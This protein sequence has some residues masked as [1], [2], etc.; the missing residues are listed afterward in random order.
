MDRGAENGKLETTPFEGPT[1]RPIS[2]RHEPQARRDQ[3]EGRAPHPTARQ[4]LLAALTGQHKKYTSARCY[5]PHNALVFY[6]AEKK[7]V[8]F[9]EI[10]FTCLN[11]KTRPDGAA[12]FIDYPALAS[13]FEANQSPMG[14]Y[15]GAA[16]FN[17]LFERT[18]ADQ[19]KAKKQNDRTTRARRLVPISEDERFNRFVPRTSRHFQPLTTPQPLLFPCCPKKHTHFTKPHHIPRDSVAEP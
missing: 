9:V 15:R 18:S 12:T 3:Q 7:P 2:S 1:A 5:V 16:A 6:N 10:C 13:L 8:A 4:N 14:E 11:H 17:K 19:P